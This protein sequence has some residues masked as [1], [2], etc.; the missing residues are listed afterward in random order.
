MGS[1]LNDKDQCFLDH[2]A[3]EVNC[4]SGT[5]AIVFQF[6]E[7]ESQVDPLYNEP[8]SKTYKLNSDGEPGIEL[9]VSF[10]SPDRTEISGEEG[11]RTE[12]RSTF[13]VARKDLEKKDLRRPKIGDIWILWGRHYDVVQS[14]ATTGRFTDS[15]VT[16]EYEVTV[17]RRT[18]AA[19]ESVK[20]VPRPEPDPNAKE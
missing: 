19:P 13:F 3:Q 5:T 15:G 7:V 12:K 4:L 11:Q 10:K 14:S 17:V 9:P 1:L 16:S 6:E 18:K 8:V 20:I 2:I